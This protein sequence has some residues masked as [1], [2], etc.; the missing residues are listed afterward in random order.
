[1]KDLPVPGLTRASFTSTRSGLPAPRLSVGRS[2]GNANLEVQIALY[3]ALMISPM[4]MRVLDENARHFGVSILEA[5]EKAGRGV[6]DVLL[7]EF[8]ATGKPVAI[9]VG[10][11]NNGGD[12]LVAAFHLRNV[13]KVTVVLARDSQRFSTHEARHQWDRVRGLVP[14]AEA[15]Q[16]GRVLHE[17]DLVVDALLGIGAAGAI[18][19]PYRA[20][21]A[22]INAS[23]KPVVSVDVPSGFGGD[24]AVKPTATVTM[25]AA[26]AGM[27]EANSGK[28]HVV[29]IGFGGEVGSLCGPGDF[30][31]YPVPG[32]DSHKGENGRLLVV[33]GGPYTGAPAFVAFGAYGIGVDVVH[34]ATPT[35]AYP[36]VAGFSPSFIVHP[37]AGT[38]FHKV[39]VPLVQ[40]LLRGMDALVL[41][42]GLGS[43]PGTLEA[44]RELVAGCTVPLVLDADAMTA[45][46]GHTDLLARKRG[47]VTPHAREFETLSGEKMPA[48]LAGRAQHARAF[49]KRAGAV[50]LLKGRIDVV[51]DGDSVR[52]NRTGNPAMTVGGTGDVLAGVV[53]GLLA[54]GVAPFPAARMAAFAN[55]HA[56]DLAFRAKS[57]GLLATDV[58]DHLPEVLKAFLHAEGG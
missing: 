39:D 24:V 32:S 31:Y 52:Y 14:T 48:D 44:I 13:C 21:I 2:G 46:A 1:V 50:V 35:I 38:R 28:I 7:R 34:I 20:L 17:A 30:L 29:D 57:Y 36:V 4:E 49:A 58:A 51:T 54:K 53:G 40:N 33:S 19:E 43:D 3:R 10:T 9:L 25:H 23:G 15:G 45:L 11:G 47:V 18:Q 22:A 8:H 12:G 55:G 42:P 6:A 37:L 26:K 5:M 16:A 56:G 41:G 27:T